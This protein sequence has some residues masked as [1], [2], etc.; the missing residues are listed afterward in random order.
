MPLNYIE[1]GHGIPSVQ[2]LLDD[3]AAKK[4]AAANDQVGVF[5]LRHEKQK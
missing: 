1:G 5:C 4:A 3:V 2:K